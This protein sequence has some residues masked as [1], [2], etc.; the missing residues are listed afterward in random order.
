MK[1]FG[2]KLG[3]FTIL[4]ICSIII[5]TIGNSIVIKAMNPFKLES[6]EHILILG[7]SHTAFS[8]NDSIM[9]NA[10][11]FSNAADS[12]FYSFKKLQEIKKKN[13]QIDTLLLSF[14]GH[15]INADIE[16]RWLLNNEHI[17]DHLKIYFPLLDFNDIM[18]FLKHKPIELFKGCFSQLLLTYQLAKNNTKDYG[19]YRN[20]DNNILEDE[21][22][23]LSIRPE[24]NNTYEIATIEKVYLQKIVNYCKEHKIHLIL[25]NPPLHK[26]INQEQKHLY[27]FYEKY[28][29]E[30]T[31]YD[32]SMLEM[33]DDCFGDLVHLTPKGA[34]QFTNWFKQKKILNEKQART[35]N[36]LYK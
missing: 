7:D 5:V 13:N 34:K 17:Q 11:N 16:K 36:I 35:H 28:F 8:F 24:D 14:S 23:K 15:N 18:F 9:T 25:V 4:L 33:K 19:G 20:L 1:Q 26:A 21:L 10:R 12:Y 27:Q 29:N 32:L 22:A 2:I 6:G 3:L 31:F 30:V